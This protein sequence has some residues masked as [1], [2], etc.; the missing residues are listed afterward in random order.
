MTALEGANHHAE[1]QPC[2]AE[3]NAMLILKLVRSK[4]DVKSFIMN[5]W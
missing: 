4:S 5:A 2:W 3:A 1:Q